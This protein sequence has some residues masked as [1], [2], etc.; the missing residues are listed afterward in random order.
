MSCPHCH[1]VMN[2]LLPGVMRWCAR[3]GTLSINDEHV[4]PAMHRDAELARAADP[5]EQPAPH[6]RSLSAMSFAA[7]QRLRQRCREEGRS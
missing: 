4:S 1:F 2:E 6:P 5:F 7:A 3:C